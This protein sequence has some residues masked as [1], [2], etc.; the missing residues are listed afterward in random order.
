MAQPVEP[1]AP[2]PPPQFDTPELADLSRYLEQELARVA[3]GINFVS[4]Q[5]MY[6]GLWLDDAPAAQQ[7][8]T[9]T[10][11]AVTGFDAVTPD[12]PNRT[13]PDA[14][15]DSITVLDSGVVM[16]DASMAINL[17]S[18]IFVFQ[19]YINGTPTGIGTVV[20]PSDQTDFDGV[21]LHG[22]G[23]VQAGDVLQLSVRVTSGTGNITLRS[24]MFTVHRVSEQHRG[25]GFPAAA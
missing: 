25:G 2:F 6:G 16:I 24:A 21:S 5:S 11:A 17:S 22:L 15:A 14:G 1:Y 23:T 8:V 7:N 10:P 4:V 18:G 13:D 9:T 20:D 19:I 3:T 12:V